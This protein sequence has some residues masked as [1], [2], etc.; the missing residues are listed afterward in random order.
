MYY[1]FT[2]IS[3][4]GKTGPIPVTTTHADSCPDNCGAK[5]KFCY[6][7]FGPLGMHWNRLTQGI[8]KSKLLWHE[9]LDKI[10]ALP[11]GLRWRHNQAGDLDHKN[12]KIDKNKL[13]DLVYANKGKRGFTYTHHLLNWHNLESLV[14]AN[15]AGFTIN[16]SLDSVEQIDEFEKCP[17]PLVVILP[18][19][20]PKVSF[21]P[22]GKKIVRCPATWRDDFNC[23]MCDLCMRP[24]RNFVVGFPV[25]GVGKGKFNG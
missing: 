16:Y 22:K 5:G 9:L 2:R 15:K 6:A 23:S 18:E 12:G 21:S 24:E 25:H 14:K 1:L 10:A 19:N 20:A 8:H 7:R 17:L 4:N 13:E 3:N 11:S